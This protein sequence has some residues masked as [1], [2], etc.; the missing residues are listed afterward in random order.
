MTKDHKY[1]CIGLNQLR[2]FRFVLIQFH[3]KTTPNQTKTNKTNKQTNKQN[4]E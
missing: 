3:S 1:N 2:T 4:P